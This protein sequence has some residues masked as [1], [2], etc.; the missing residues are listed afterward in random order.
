MVNDLAWTAERTWEVDWTTLFQEHGH[1]W[2]LKA[3]SRKQMFINI[4]WMSQKKKKNQGLKKTACYHRKWWYHELRM[5]TVLEQHMSFS[6]LLAVVISFYLNFQCQLN[7]AL[8]S[9]ISPFWTIIMFK[10]LI[11]VAVQDVQL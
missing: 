10:K 2:Y 6:S 3:F 11:R 5:K 8:Q 1:F 4:S 9:E 7:P